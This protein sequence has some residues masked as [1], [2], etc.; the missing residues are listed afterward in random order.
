MLTIIGVILFMLAV[1]A[2]PVLDCYLIG[3]ELLET[4][5]SFGR[6]VWLLL[7]GAVFV[8]LC[9]PLALLVLCIR[10]W[11]WLSG[12]LRAVGVAALW[13]LLLVGSGLMIILA[14][15]EITETD[16]LADYRVVTGNY[17]NRRPQTFI[18]S[19]F[20]AEI[21]EDFA[22][23]IWH[24]KAKKFDSIGCEA[25][26]EFTLPEEAAFAA[27]YAGLAQHGEPRAFP[28][29]ARYEMWVIDNRMD[30]WTSSERGQPDREVPDVRNIEEASVGLILCEPEAQRFVYFALMVHDGGA[31]DES[32]LNYF[33]DRFGVEMWRFENA[34]CQ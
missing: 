30:A 20:P 8:V 22:D 15:V 10:R 27:H 7:L 4:K 2:L 5:R 33:F 31:T 16:N 29:D 18:D 11:G 21:G 24:Y 17:N 9:P 12:L 28:F 13:V 19:F 1:L 23:S 32:D 14:P 6:N 26:L 34:I 25:Y 3:A